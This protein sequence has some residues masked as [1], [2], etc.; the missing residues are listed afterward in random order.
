MPEEINHDRR[1]LLGTF[2]AS[3][4]ITIAA[5]ELGIICSAEARSSKDNLTGTTLIQLPAD[6]N[7]KKGTPNGTPDF[8]LHDADRWVLHLL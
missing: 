7:R 3:S 1:R 6:T 8:V 2:F 5:A 4:A